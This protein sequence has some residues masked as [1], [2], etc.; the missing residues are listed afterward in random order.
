MFF[1]SLHTGYVYDI[2]FL[3][4]NGPIDR[5]PCVLWVEPVDLQLFWGGGG[6]FSDGANSVVGGVAVGGSTFDRPTDTQE[7]D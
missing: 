2:P 3:G 4:V 1:D 5:T 7:G 6:G